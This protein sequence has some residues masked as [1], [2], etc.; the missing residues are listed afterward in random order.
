MRASG[1][2]G[3]YRVRPAAWF[4]L[5]QMLVQASDQNS[6]AHLYRDSV[7]SVARYRSGAQL[8]PSGHLSRKGRSF[9]QPVRKASTWE[10]SRTLCGVQKASVDRSSAPGVVRQ[11]TTGMHHRRIAEFSRTALARPVSF[12]RSDVVHVDWVSHRPGSN[13]GID[14]TI[15]TREGRPPPGFGSFRRCCPQSTLRTMR[16]VLVNSS[17]PQGGSLRTQTVACGHR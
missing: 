4:G 11:A 14:A 16:G 10:R 6:L 12:S 8:S 13:P 5:V 2:L 17:F 9:R 7:G 1:A 3:A 15:A